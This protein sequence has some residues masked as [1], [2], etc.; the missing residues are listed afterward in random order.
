MRG[1]KMNDIRNCP[2]CGNKPVSFESNVATTFGDAK[3]YIIECE[4]DS[5]DKVPFIEHRIT[6]YGRNK[7]ESIQ[8]WNKQG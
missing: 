3:C 7:K 6:V 4:S 5:P 8:K 2:I 1:I